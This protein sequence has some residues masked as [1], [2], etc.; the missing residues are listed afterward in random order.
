MG[1]LYI[2]GSTGNR[3]PVPEDAEIVMAFPS[4]ASRLKTDKPV[5][6]LPY[7]LEKAL[8]AIEAQAEEKKVAVVLSGDPLFYGWGAELKKHFPRATVI[9]WL[10]YVQVAFSLIGRP[11]DR[12]EVVSLHGR[13][14]HSL[15]KALTKGKE[16]I[17]AY[18]DRRNSPEKIAQLLIEQEVPVE[19]FWVFE[20]L[21]TEKERYGCYSP[22][23][24]AKLSFRDPNC[25]IVKLPELEVPSPWEDHAYTTRKGL[26]TKARIRAIVSSIIPE[27]DVLWDVGAGSGAVSITLSRNYSLVFAVEPKHADLVRENRR[28]FAA[29]NVMTVEGEA[30]EALKDLP[31]PTNVFIG[32]G[33]RNLKDIAKEVLKRV[34]RRVVGTFVSPEGLKS[35][36]AMKEEYGGTLTQVSFCH[37]HQGPARATTPVWIWVWERS[38]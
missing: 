35:A 37:Y 26:L 38:T 22:E 15:L 28:R 13:D 31:E 11:W 12:A 1:R 25:V 17:F 27:G 3:A 36:L 8:K 4:V 23:E 2:V 6:V 9:P 24:A 20:E 19:E 30:P 33:H 21:A 10:S 14:L 32:S 5:E 16:Y 18:T 34:K 29:W 7:P